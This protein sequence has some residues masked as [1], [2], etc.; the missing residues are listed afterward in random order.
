VLGIVEQLLGARGVQALFSRE[1]RMEYATD[2]HQRSNTQVHQS[3]AE[4][5]EL[6]SA[7]GRVCAMADSICSTHKESEKSM[8]VSIILV[9]IMP[10]VLIILLSLITLY[11]SLPA[12]VVQILIGFVVDLV[13]NLVVYFV[14][15]CWVSSRS[16][17]FRSSKFSFSLRR[18]LFRSELDG[19]IRSRNRNQ[20]S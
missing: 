19:W 20:S 11:L 9:L 6:A 3:T 4:R 2:G 15:V 12:A 10:L 14:A 5:W 18:I 8:V 16:S 13:L 7:M 1:D 17:S